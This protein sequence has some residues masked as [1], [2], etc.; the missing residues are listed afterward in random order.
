MKPREFLML[1]GLRDCSFPILGTGTFGVGPHEA[2]T[3]QLLDR[4]RERGGNMGI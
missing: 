3:F 1:N 2:T 4:Y